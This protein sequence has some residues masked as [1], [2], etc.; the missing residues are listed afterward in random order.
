MR[1]A[2]PTFYLNF[3]S[4]ILVSGIAA[5]IGGNNGIAL[6]K[7]IQRS[8]WLTGS[9]VRLMR[10]GMWLPCFLLWTYSQFLLA[11]E[12]PSIFRL[13]P[14]SLATDNKRVLF[15]F[16]IGMLAMTT[17]LLGSCYHYLARHV[18][19]K[20]Y[21]HS[22]P[23]LH[24][25]REIFLLALL[26]CLVWQ[27]VFGNGWPFQLA[28][29]FQDIRKD[30]GFLMLTASLAMLLFTVLVV[31]VNK[32]F[33]WQLQ[34]AAAV[35]AAVMLL[36][37][38]GEL[39]N[40]I[41]MYPTLTAWLGMF[42]L[43][44]V[45]L[46]GNVMTRWSMVGVV[47]MRHDLLW[48]ELKNANGQSLMGAL[49]LAIAALFLWELL[50]APLSTY[51]SLP[52]PVDVL[53]AIASLLVTGTNLMGLPSRTVVWSDIRLSLLEIF[54][55]TLW[56]GL[57]AM[58]TVAWCYRRSWLEVGGALL[59]LTAISPIVLGE[60][61]IIWLGLG[62]IRRAFVVSCFAFFPMVQAFWCYRQLS[63]PARLLIATD[64]ALPYS[65]LGMLVGQMISTEG[66]GFFIMVASVTKHEAEAFA[67]TFILF[68]I[69][70]A[71]SGFFRWAIKKEGLEA[72]PDALPEPV[73]AV[74]AAV[75]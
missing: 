10:V 70:A 5:V 18:A 46:I 15:S 57:L 49:A 72:Q 68:G 14:F 65:F 67:A 75:P 69:L 54:T 66:L 6:G 17:V 24:L 45:V 47:K 3:I 30:S 33:R 28:R 52:R 8:R 40:P 23:R 11:N 41:F 26:L 71:F 73:I 59:A 58:F 2:D 37:I 25:Q 55:G 62:F 63:F 20:F 42:L 53:Q 4:L 16:L 7:L 19:P 36:S 29:W 32:P 51:A 56:A 12:L 1:L 39:I 22:Y 13:Y 61:A 64:E 9:T 50:S 43:M 38:W 60:V 31:V 34:L 21:Q 35:F 27:T 44:A 74:P 48:V